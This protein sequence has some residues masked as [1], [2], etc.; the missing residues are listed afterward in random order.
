MQSLF[1]YFGAASSAGDK[2]GLP[3]YLLELLDNWQTMPILSR[4]A[5]LKLMDELKTRG[6]ADGIAAVLA[7]GLY[8]LTRQSSAMHAAES[9]LH[10]FFYGFDRKY[11]YFRID[12][13]TVLDKTLQ[14]G[15]SIQLHLIRGRECCLPMR[16]DKDHGPPLVKDGGEW[17]ETE[18]ICRW[19]IVRICEVQ[20]PLAAINPEPGGK[21]FAFIT[22]VR[23]GDEI[24]R[25]PIDAAELRR[26]SPLDC[27]Q[28]E[29]DWMGQRATIRG[30]ILS[31]IR[32]AG[33]LQLRDTPRS[34]P[35]PSRRHATS[36]RNVC[37]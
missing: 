11:F 34:R 3:P 12:G 15:D 27:N 25:W 23:W 32:P 21:L 35:L 20:V 9:F 16:V 31:C 14:P 1:K 29:E 36:N 5:N 8:D 4:P 18:H 17:K 26:P 13:A 22:L 7:A 10:S 24:G 28:R 6:H 33:T 30:P 37:S 19:K 2:N